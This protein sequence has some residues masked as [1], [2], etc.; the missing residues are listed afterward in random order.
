MLA[1]AEHTHVTHGHVLARGQLLAQVLE[2]PGGVGRAV[3]RAVE[4]HV[5]LARPPGLPEVAHQRAI[6]RALAPGPGLDLRRRLLDAGHDRLRAAPTHGGDDRA[7]VGVE[8]G[9]VIAPVGH[10]ALDALELRRGRLQQQ[11]VEAVLAEERLGEEAPGRGLVVLAEADDRVVPRVELGQPVRGRLL[12]PPQLLEHALLLLRRQGP[13]IVER[14]LRRA[15]RDPHLRRREQVVLRRLGVVLAVPDHGRDDHQHQQRPA[16]D[17]E[18]H[19]QHG[20][21]N[22]GGRSGRCQ[23]CSRARLA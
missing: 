9:H 20:S 8:Q 23:Y 18:D 5:A 14:V 21:V 7:D 22:R 13:Q 11:H 17:D 6:A 1:G 10:P 15:H 12:D 2:Q 4:D 16:Q 3:Q 19:S